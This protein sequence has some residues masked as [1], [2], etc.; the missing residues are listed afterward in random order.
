MAGGCSSSVSQKLITDVY[1]QID[2]RLLCLRI[3]LR[4]QVV[5]I[6]FLRWLVNIRHIA[7]DPG[8]TISRSRLRLWSLFTVSLSALQKQ[9]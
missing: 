4:P 8:R 9:R 1:E 6:R 5:E 3:E 2:D 7:P